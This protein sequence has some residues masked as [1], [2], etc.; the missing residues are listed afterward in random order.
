MYTATDAAGNVAVKTRTVHVVDEVAP[1]VSGKVGG[2]LR[3]GVGSQFNILDFVLFSDNYDSPADLV[4]NHTLVY[5][6]VNVWEPG[7]YTSIFK[8]HD[9]SGNYSGEFTLY[10][11]VDYDYF[12]LKGNV[13]DLELD[14]LLSIYPNPTNGILNV[15]V[16]T[17]SNELIT[18]QL[19]NSIGQQIE[20][21]ANNSSNDGLYSLNLSDQSSGVY[22]IKL[23]VKEKVVTKKV[24]LEN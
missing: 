17:A 6:D 7:T 24:I 20:S 14:K 11:D 10:V 13:S 19:F 5:N 23:T 12:P 16:N 22:Y 8:T 2:A 4:A 3:V 15:N 21:L 18:L 1:K 9:N